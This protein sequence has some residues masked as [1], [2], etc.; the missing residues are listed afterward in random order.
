MLALVEKEIVPADVLDASADFFDAE[1]GGITGESGKA[2]AQVDACQ[3]RAGA[4]E[5]EESGSFDLVGG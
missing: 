4:D 2:L 5:G 1:D 3:L